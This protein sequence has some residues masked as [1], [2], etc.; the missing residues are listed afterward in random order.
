MSLLWNSLRRFT[1]LSFILVS[2]LAYPAEVNNTAALICEDPSSSLL[3]HATSTNNPA[4][5][6][7]LLGSLHVGKPEFY[8][9]HPIIEAAFRAADH[10]VFE[11]DPQSVASAEIVQTIQAR[12][13]LPQGQ[14][15]TDVVSADTVANLRQVLQEMNLPADAFFSMQPWFL[16]LVLSNLQTNALGYSPLYGVESYLLNNRSASTDILEL[17]SIEEQIGFLEQMNTEVFLNYTLKSFK[18]SATLLAALISSWQCADKDKLSDMIFDDFNTADSSSTDS[19][20][21][22][23]IVELDKIQEM[24]FFKRNITMADG[25]KV[26]LTEGQGNYF[27]VVGSGH[28]LGEKSVID[29]LRQAGYEINPVSLSQ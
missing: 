24:L 16:T 18:D 26:F 6:V 4:V 27:V 21:A 5:E 2:P 19:P 9:F 20:S 11:V 14:S 15:L 7:Y 1:L 8:P 13:L 17:E 10:L 23:E 22:E 28:L 29:L 12:G 25:V 3:W